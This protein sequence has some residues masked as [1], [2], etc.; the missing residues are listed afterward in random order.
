[1]KLKLNKEKTYSGP[2]YLLVHQ[3]T[4]KEKDAAPFIFNKS[5]YKP[6]ESQISELSKK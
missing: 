4:S 3:Q 5:I 6:N 2:D 1:M